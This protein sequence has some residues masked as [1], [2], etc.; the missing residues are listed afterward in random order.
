MGL[1]SIGEALHQLGFIAAKDNSSQKAIDYYNES[2][3]SRQKLFKL[4]GLHEP[5]M[6]QTLVN[7]G[8]VL[9]ESIFPTAVKEQMNILNQALECAKSAK[10]IYKR[11]I[12][13]GI[14]MTECN[15]YESLQLEGTIYYALW[16]ST[17]EEEFFNKS[18]ECCLI[19]WK[20]NIQHPLNHYQN[21]FKNYSGE[22]LRKHGYI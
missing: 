12:I 4:T 7:K 1:F 8:A 16:E 20:W 2:F 10:D 21:A 11:Y 5:T 13:P 22:I 15:Y 18:I 6:A 3:K 9:L 17:K 19:C 14:E